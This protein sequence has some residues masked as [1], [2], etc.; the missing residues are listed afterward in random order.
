MTP[1]AMPRSAHSVTVL[2]AATKMLDAKTIQPEATHKFRLYSLCPS[3]SKSALTSK[4]E[5][6]SLNSKN[7]SYE[8]LWPAIRCLEVHFLAAASG[9]HTCEF[10]PDAKA[11]NR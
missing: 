9:N 5:G 4:A 7:R 10:K 3:F 2:L 8:H 11:R 6:D 1:M